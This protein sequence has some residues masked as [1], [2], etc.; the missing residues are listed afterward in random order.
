V[1]C[2]Y[3]TQQHHCVFVFQELENDWVVI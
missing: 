1:V 2:T 3:K